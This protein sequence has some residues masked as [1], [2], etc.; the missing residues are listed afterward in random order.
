MS[1]EVSAAAASEDHVH[2]GNYVKVWA[3]LVVLLIISVL[4]PLTGI[5]WLVLFT[6]FGIAIIKA[7]M[8]AKNFMHV[9]VERRWVGYLLITCLVFLAILFAG[10]A[11]DIMKHQ[12]LHWDNYAA[13]QAV[14]SGSKDGG[15]HE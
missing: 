11:P 15:K 5:R 4:G 9:N 8:V 13:K 7:Y 3:I 10:V 14:Q 1:S 12:G 2:H 6:A